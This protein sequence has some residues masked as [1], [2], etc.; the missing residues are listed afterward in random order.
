MAQEPSKVVAI[1]NLDRHTTEESI[2][3]IVGSYG[4]VEVQYVNAEWLR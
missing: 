1:S 2:L 3:R 4:N